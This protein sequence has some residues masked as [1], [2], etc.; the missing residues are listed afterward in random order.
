MAR[1][2]NHHVR[3]HHHMRIY[4]SWWHVAAT[5]LLIVVPLAFLFVFAHFAKI[6]SSTLFYDMGISVARLTVAYAIAAVIGWALAV[7]FFRGR[8]AVIALPFFDVLQSF[9]TYA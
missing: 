5:F 1:N 6:T 7:S 9:P 8:R 4:R 3:R 2:H